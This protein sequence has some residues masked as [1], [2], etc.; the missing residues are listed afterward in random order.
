MQLQTSKQDI[1]Y[2][3]IARNCGI[4]LTYVW[5][6]INGKRKGKRHRPKIEAFLR[7]YNAAISE[8]K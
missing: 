1:P 4:S 3:V 5:A 7:K 8:L 6:I 2:S